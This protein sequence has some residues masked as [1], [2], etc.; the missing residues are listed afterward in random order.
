MATQQLLFDILATSK[1]VDK[2][3]QDVVDSADTMAGKLGAAGSKATAKLFSPMT[4]AAAGGIAGA[5]LMSGLTT[6]I[7]MD[8]VTSTMTAG[9]NL[10]GPAAAAAGQAAGQMYAD[11]YGD[12][13]ESV[14]AG[15]EATLSSIK[16][17]SGQS[18]ADIQSV[19]SKVMDL[20]A[21]FGMDVGRAAQVAGQMINTGLAKD[22]VEAAD[23]L[24]ATLA[25]V[26]VNVRED[27]L[28][29]VDEYGPMFANLGMSGGEAMTLLADA[30]AKGA[31]GIDKTGDA[32]KEFTIRATD[33]SKAT[34]GAYESL[35][36][37]QTDMTN[38]L[39]AG[40]DTARAAFDKIIMGLGDIKDPAQQ[41]QAALA[42][43]GTPIEDLGTAEI[44]KF[45]DSL[46][47][48][49]EALGTVEGSA[50]TLGE[51]LHSG[52]GAAFTELQ[53]KAE[54]TLGQ[55]GAQMLPILT[56]ILEGLQQF[57]PVI[58]PAV[59]ALGALA[60]VIAVV[61]MVMAVSPI[62]W[63]VIGVVAL[64]A[65]IVALVMN[66]DT[67]VAFLTQAWAGFVGWFQGVMAGF[68]GWWDGVWGGF[69]G[70]T[71]DVWNGFVG[72]LGDVW[73]GFMGWI[74]GIIGGF[75]GFW[76]S[77]WSTI[78]SFIA[79][80]WAGIVAAATAG[81][82]AFVDPI[83]N[84]IVGVWNFITAIFTN[85]GN[86]IAGVWNWIT[87]LVGNIIKAFVQEHGDEMQAIWDNI[88]AVF[89]AIGGFF[90][91]IWNWYVG[92]ITGALQAVW[93]VIST[94]FT[95][96]WGFIS[97]VF[98]AIGAFIGGVWNWYVGVITAA[99]QAV[100]GVVS[101]VFSAV[102][103]FI[104]EVFTA[105]GGFI[106]GVWNNI[107]AVI[108][109][110]VG[111]VWGTIV[112]G[113]SAAWNFITSVFGQVAGFLGGIWGNI[114]SGVSGMIGQVGGFFSGLWGTITGALSG[115]GRWLWDA[116][117]NIVNGLFDGIK[118]LAGTIGN[119]FLGLLPGWIVEPFKVALGIHSPSTVFAG[120]GENIGEGVLV[121]VGRVQGR[122]DDRMSSLVTVPE[123]GAGSG[124][125]SSSTAGGRTAGGGSTIDD[126]ID[127]IRTQ[128]PINVQAPP[129]TDPELVGR[130]TAEQ[131]LWR[132]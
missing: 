96:V 47:N 52:P 42:L 130:A 7:N 88:V 90:T 10:T 100:W 12:S 113:F 95:T 5:A 54:T 118:S 106:G 86:F 74:Q 32:L 38:Q 72:F 14:T 55:L 20:S 71:Q 128:R 58:V 116:G 105:V 98:T 39:L 61:N 1:G 123:F 104:S 41:S 44:P 126:L 87:S 31:Y 103:G 89:T 111:A 8:S 18:Q 57:A 37:D 78:G 34:S 28:D 48:S 83:V 45:I 49:Q 30:S 101:A 124:F 23:L 81:V 29:A 94:V 4:A 85:I 21:A 51:K 80:V 60:A 35:G 70:W 93:G 6:A 2:T 63:I 36:M 114:V 102:W 62:G 15:V 115:A 92:I 120:F 107:V 127:V 68:F 84:G 69:I 13:F 50:A 19:T 131:I 64:I 9:L 125:G 82:H 109:G 26:P 67:V 77:T 91:G 129:G 75:L 110:A 119:F 43:F 16:G 40:G 27:V 121:G 117:V 24:A 53:R 17:L 122:I 132:G 97:G 79:G 22:G 46:L 59:I 66:W 25:K 3:F 73:G 65:A 76:N 112:N 11:G 99:L 33:M 56:P 108:S